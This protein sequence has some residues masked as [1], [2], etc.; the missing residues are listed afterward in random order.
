MKK[1]FGTLAVAIVGLFATTTA[2]ASDVVYEERVLGDPNAPVTVIEY[3]SFTCPHCANFHNKVMPQIKKEFIDTGKV[4]FIY[5]DFPF[6]RAGA[7]ASMLARCVDPQRFT[8]FVDML[9]KQQAQWARADNPLAALTRLSKLAG[10]SEEGVNACI[11]NEKLLDE[12]VAVRK[13]AMETYGFNSTPSFL[14]NGEKVVGGGEFER[15][16]S[17]IEGKL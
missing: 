12:I 1:F 14:I 6:D 7:T 8:G 10:L 13:N 3:A 5:R 17:I 2:Q 9:M 11:R 15:F 16:K 4:K